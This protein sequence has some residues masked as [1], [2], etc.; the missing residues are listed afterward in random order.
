VV[1]A[2]RAATAA[3]PLRLRWHVTVPTPP[4]PNRPRTQLH[5]I[6][7]MLHG[8]PIE[9]LRFQSSFHRRPTPAVAMDTPKPSSP[10]SCPFQAVPFKLTLQRHS[11]SLDEAHRASFLLPQAAS[12]SL[13]VNLQTPPCATVAGPLRRFPGWRAP[14][15]GAP[16]SP[17]A[18][19]GVAALRRAASHHRR[20]YLKILPLVNSIETSR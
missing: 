1:A 5:D 11:S 14:Q 20:W 10:L 13:A 17:L 3:V 7:V 9:A 19:H 16:R 18:S 4:R 6:T 12:C 15:S 2:V 8:W